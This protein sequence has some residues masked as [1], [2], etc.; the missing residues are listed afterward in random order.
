M[1]ADEAHDVGQRSPSFSWA[2]RPKQ[3]GRR[4]VNKNKIEISTIAMNAISIP[5]EYHIEE[6]PININVKTRAA[7]PALAFAFNIV[8]CM[9]RI[10]KLQ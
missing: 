10:G 4:A 3:A 6:G 1:D 8:Q 2:Q 7:G 5:H 9:I